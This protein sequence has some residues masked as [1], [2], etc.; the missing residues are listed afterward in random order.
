ME[1]VERKIKIIR[2]F[3]EG[4]EKCFTDED[5]QEIIKCVVGVD[6]D[7]INTRLSNCIRTP[8]IP[9][10][11]VKLAHREPPFIITIPDDIDNISNKALFLNVLE[12]LLDY[13]A[14]KNYNKV[15]GHLTVKDLEWARLSDILDSIL[16]LSNILKWDKKIEIS[17]YII[18]IKIRNI[19]E[20]LSEAKKAKELYINSWLASIIV[21]LSIEQLVKKYG[22]DIVLFPNIRRAPLLGSSVNA[23]LRGDP[24]TMNLLRKVIKINGKEKVSS[25]E[26]IEIIDKV[27]FNYIYKPYG[28]PIFATIPSDICLVINEKI[29]R[30]I[31]ENAHIK[32]SNPTEISPRNLCSAFDRILKRVQGYISEKSLRYLIRYIRDLFDIEDISCLSD[33]ISDFEKKRKKFMELL[34]EAIHIIS[35][36]NLHKIPLLDYDIVVGEVS[37]KNNECKINIYTSV[38]D[39]SESYSLNLDIEPDIKQRV[40]I[41]KFSNLIQTIFDHFFKA[42]KKLLGKFAGRRYDQIRPYIKYTYMKYKKRE[43][44]RYCSI[45]GFRPAVIEIPPRRIQIKKNVR[46]D[47]YEDVVPQII[48]PY[49]DSKEYLCGHCLIKRALI[50]P[51]VFRNVFKEIFGEDINPP[52]KII[53]TTD[54]ATL[55]DIIQRKEIFRDIARIFENPRRNWYLERKRKRLKSCLYQQKYMLRR[56]PRVIYKKLDELPDDESRVGFC[57][58]MNLPL[59]VIASVDELQEIND[60]LKDILTSF[61]IGIIY[62]DGDY[63]GK[64]ISLNFEDG[65]LLPI[66]CI[67]KRTVLRRLFG[68]DDVSFSLTYNR[69]ISYSITVSSG[70]EQIIFLDNNAHLFLDNEEIDDPLI[71][72]I[73]FGGDDV[74]IMSHVSDVFNVFRILRLTFTNGAEVDFNADKIKIT[75]H[76]HKNSKVGF[77]EYFG[78]TSIAFP[79]LTRS[80]HV[81]LMHHKYPLAKAVL[82]TIT[83]L[84]AKDEIELH[85]KSQIYKKDI[86]ITSLLGGGTIDTATLPISFIDTVN[87]ARY[88]LCPKHNS[89]IDLLK[90]YV[91]FIFGDER[92]VFSKSLIYDI[93]RSTEILNFLKI[94]NEILAKK[95]ILYH[96][97]RNLLKETGN[98]MN[99]KD[100]IISSLDQ[101]LKIRVGFSVKDGNTIISNIKNKLAVEYNKVLGKI[102]KQTKIH[103]FMELIHVL[104]IYNS[105]I[106][107]EKFIK[108]I[109][110]R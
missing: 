43:R 24:E 70:I 59:D 36:Y 101:L 1:L 102:Y 34:G 48:Q 97:R 71:F 98:W 65:E 87:K 91:D 35:E 82:D 12:I 39:K 44:Y 78:M 27:S 13:I 89:S 7:N 106:K 104:K 10:I 63:F 38:L 95:M 51:F 8:F 94:D 68:R 14:I 110:G 75:I 72:P 52:P 54:I 9:D 37:S 66:G 58:L 109:G 26:I 45:C 20:F 96:M 60:K 33:K 103:A 62:C 108:V 6:I 47:A 69:V 31:V 107:K 76:T 73:L 55:K 64:H 22:S 83:G 41:G 29:A 11:T 25:G 32:K 3:I 92:K 21:W 2:K 23:D 67:D 46:K 90:M 15:L 30:D 53:S 4:I 56:H 79:H 42:S 18:R 40:I 49:F 88:T 81:V 85:I 74:I 99:I 86:L 50:I 93:F 100:K 61:Y 105:A 77:N 28:F 57:Y 84:D 19:H 16:V 80:F 17:G 5:F